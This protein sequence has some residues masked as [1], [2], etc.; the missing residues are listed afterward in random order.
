MKDFREAI[1]YLML[2]AL[3]LTA[4]LLI[5]DAHASDLDPQKLETWTVSPGDTLWAIAS[6]HRGKLEIRRYI[7]EIEKL[8]DINGQI[9]PGQ[10]IILPPNK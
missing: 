1:V 9:Y 4:I 10:R 5:Q 3:I 7:Y 6:Q 8:N 2:P